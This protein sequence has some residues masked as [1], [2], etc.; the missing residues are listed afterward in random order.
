VLAAASA[1][2]VPATAEAHAIVTPSLVSAG[3]SE[4]SGCA[5]RT[6]GGTLR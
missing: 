2:A 6:S 5:C 3:A 4:R 1:L